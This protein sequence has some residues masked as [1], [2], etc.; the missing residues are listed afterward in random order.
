MKVA[1]VTIIQ[2]T[3]FTMKARVSH[4]LTNKL[5]GPIPYALLNLTSDFLM[6]Y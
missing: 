5:K 4:K 6:D 1:M 3:Y 2:V